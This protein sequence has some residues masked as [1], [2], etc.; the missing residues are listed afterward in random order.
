MA[1]IGRVE[2]GT[3]TESSAGVVAKGI[4]RTENSNLQSVWGDA[5]KFTAYGQVAQSVEQWTENPRVGGSIPP[6]ATN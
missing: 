6:L 5:K 3:E 4:Q 2:S 1:A